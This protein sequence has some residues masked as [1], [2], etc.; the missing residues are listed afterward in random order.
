MPFTSLFEGQIMPT[1]ACEID[2]R[3][4]N[5][6]E[7]MAEAGYN[8]TYTFKDY[9]KLGLLLRVRGHRAVWLAK[10]KQSTKTIGQL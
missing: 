1:E 2:R 3:I 8:G 7:K 9:G 4:V 6:A 10:Y 5:R